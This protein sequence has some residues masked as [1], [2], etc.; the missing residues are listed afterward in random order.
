MRNPVCL[1]VLSCVPL[2]SQTASR[3]R[4]TLADAEQLAIRNHP[5]LQSARFQA[6]ALRAQVPQVK[7]ALAPVLVGN[8]TGSAADNGSRLGAGGLNASSLFSRFGAGIGVSQTL[9]DFGRTNKLA[10]SAA[11]RADAQ[12]VTV[13]A[14]RGELILQI[15]QAYLRVLETQ[16]ALQLGQQ[17]LQS[18]QLI[19][20]QVQAFTENQL[21]STLDLQFAEVAVSEAETLLAR[22]EGELEAANAT[23]AAALG[24]IDERRFELEEVSQPVMLPLSVDS[25]VE[26]ALNTRPELIARRRQQEAARQFAVSESR[27]TLPSVSTTG[28][29]GFIPT[30]DP[31]LRSRYGG[32]GLNIN[33][34]VFNGRI[35]D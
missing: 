18:R 4:L 7:A 35:F 3:E 11:L 8:L 28:A 14:V 32:L 31:R 21:R 19:R 6:N 15:R 2:L 17:S 30:G 23:L 29:F 9:Y 27:L 25:L 34:P 13:D 10:E 24:F 1:I 12:D 26:E 20:R 16:R 22:L 33:I 5:R